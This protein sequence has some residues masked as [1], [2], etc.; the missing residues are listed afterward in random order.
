MIRPMGVS[1]LDLYASYRYYV[2]IYKNMPFIGGSRVK[3]RDVE[4]EVVLR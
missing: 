1:D 4:K 2:C 3:S